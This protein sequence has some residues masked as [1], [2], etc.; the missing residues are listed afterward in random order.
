MEKP[1]LIRA[2]WVVT[3]DPRLGVLRDGEVLV[4][5]G[6]IS[7]VG[8]RLSQREGTDIWE[9]TNMIVVPG[10][11]DTHRHTWQSILRG[12]AADWTAPQYRQ[13]VRAKLGPHFRP[14]DVYI[15][16]LLGRL[17]ALDAGVTTLVDW[18]HIT[19]SPAHVDAGI[20]ALKAAGGKAVY[21][22][23]T[24]SDD[25]FRDWYLNSELP[26]PPDVRRIVERYA[27]GT[28]NSLFVA[29]GARPP[30]NV[31]RRVLE[32][33][34]HLA[35]ELGI[36]ITVDGVGQGRWGSV[37]REPVFELHQLRLLG[38]DITFVHCNNLTERELQLMAD[39]GCSAS[40][41]PEVEM[42]VGHGFPATGRLLA[43]GIR[44]SLSVDIPCQV[45]GDMFAVMR[46]TLQAERALM[47]VRAADQGSWVREWRLTASDVLAFATA[48]GARACGLLER[49]GSI[50]PGKDADLIFIRATD[51]NVGPVNDPVAAVV[52]YSQPQNVDTV[53]VAGQIVKKDGQLLG[54]DLLKVMEQALSSRDSVLGRAGVKNP[55]DLAVSVD[56]TWLW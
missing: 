26:H 12:L 1:L 8:H 20:A 54:V 43:V 21:A 55:S 46:S 51:L 36:R 28:S 35:R 25:R 23:G 3:C 38:P 24:P 4:E 5:K 18:A 45:S 31:S 29:L 48:E 40:L 49:I 33:D 6:K 41:S 30:H 50:T 32:H 56:S 39:H 15:S 42:N 16:T 52:F 2:Q 13:G 34:F 7:A 19:N 22:Y 10:F 17:E 44:P 9:A 53:M 14:E 11:V 37:K 47:T 27:H